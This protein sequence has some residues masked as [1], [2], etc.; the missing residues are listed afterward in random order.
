MPKFSK[1][2]RDIVARCPYCN[3]RLDLRYYP[4]ELF[5]AIVLHFAEGNDRL[6]IKHFG[7]FYTFDHGAQKRDVPFYKGMTKPSRRLRFHASKSVTDLLNGKPVHHPR[8][9][10]E[11]SR[12]LRGEKRRWTP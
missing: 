12:E 8:D 10:A 5:R 9:W 7:S 11:I 1:I 2:A 3:R 6:S 4:G